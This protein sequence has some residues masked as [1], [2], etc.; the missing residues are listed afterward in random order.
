EL[1]DAAGEEH[2]DDGLGLRGE[3]R[4]AVGRGPLRRLAAGVPVAVE[5]GPERQ[6]GEPQ[7]DVGQKRAPVHRGNSGQ[8]I[9]TKSVWLNSAS[10]RFS[11]ALAPGSADGPPG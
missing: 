4:L 5:H 9:V 11:R 2:P 7:P 6:P 3:V 1:A 8:R 10:T